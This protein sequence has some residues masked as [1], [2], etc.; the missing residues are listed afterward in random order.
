[1]LI[2]AVIGF[3]YFLGN[4]E[5]IDKVFYRPDDSGVSRFRPESIIEYAKAPLSCG[6]SQFYVVWGSVPDVGLVDRLKL[7]SL[8]W[9]FC[10]GTGALVE[11]YLR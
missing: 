2:G 10:V 3:L 8:N 5:S 6:T 1:M 4:V 7:L 11:L 9:M